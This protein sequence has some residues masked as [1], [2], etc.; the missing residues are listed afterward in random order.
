MPDNIIKELSAK[1]ERFRASCIN[2]MPSENCASRDVL[3]LLSSDFSNRYTLPINEEIDGGLID[4]AY[5]GTRYTDAVEAE[6]EAL[7]RKV[8][9]CDFAS[10]RPLS[11]HIAGMVMLLSTCERGDRILTIDTDHGGYHGYMPD[12]M[13]GMLGLDV[14]FLPFDDDQWNLDTDGTVEL[15]RGER[16]RLVLVGASY[17][18]FPYVLDPIVEACQEVDAVLG[19]DGSHVLGLIG[20][21]EFQDPLREG[22]DILTGSTHKTLFGPQGG[23]VLT[24]DE[25][26][27]EEVGRNLTW[28]TLDNAH[29]NRIA[30][31]GQTLLEMDAFGTEYA[32][33]VV[34]NSRALARA[35][36][37]SGVPVRFRERGYTESHQLLLDL[38][39]IKERCSHTSASIS[40]RLEE[41]NIIVDAVGRLGTN[42]VTRLG[43]R[44]GEMVKIADLV[45]SVLLEGGDVRGE[46]RELR[47][48]LRLSFT[49]G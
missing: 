13:A 41:N 5:G 43:A 40:E 36:D 15:I 31:L 25:G 23:L 21:G 32:S 14:G 34:R 9:R 1:H 4:N 27:F 44:E 29:W 22:A 24:N 20:G 28:R 17:F 37:E 47:S 46:V 42:E 6:T 2:L 39:G 8:F 48:M 18:P 12:Y 10:V 19:Y 3:H 45:A 30:A 49:L 38:D 11:G 7:A 33:Q 16:P 26:L 35:L